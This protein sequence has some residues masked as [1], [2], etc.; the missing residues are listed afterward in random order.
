MTGSSP[1]M[2]AGVIFDCDGTLADTETLSARAWRD[3]LARRG[4]EVT[5]ADHAAIIGHAWPRGFDHFSARA[6]LGDQEVF[7]SELRAHAVAIYDEHLRLFP[8]AADTL[9]ALSGAGVPVAVA[10]SSSRAH[11][12]R[13]L[14]RGHLGDHV[15]AVIG[16]DDVRDHKPH[17]EPYLAAAAALGVPATRCTAI[18]DT[19]IGL[20]SAR[21]A[22]AFTVA[23]ER[24][25]VDPAGLTVADRVVRTLDVSVL[26]PPRDWV[27]PAA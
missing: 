4:I 23:V 20:T 1:P 15:T 9:R 27:S 24:G 16:A 3:V 14:E 22:G 17:P 6:D 12:L 19:P 5:D 11:V 8:D 21:A 13:C 18:E 10:S 2:P 25:V 7:R 26:V